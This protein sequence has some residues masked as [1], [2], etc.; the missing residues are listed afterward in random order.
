M[1]S[2]DLN[3]LEKLDETLTRLSEQMP[4]HRRELHQ[5]LAD[6]AQE[7]VRQALSEKAKD[8]TGALSDWQ[9]Q[10]V[11]DYGGYAKIQ[12]AKERFERGYAVGYIT[13]SA[14]SGHLIRKPSGRW[15]HYRARITRRY[16]PGLGF[17]ELSR[18]RAQKIAV[19]AAEELLGS[20]ARELQT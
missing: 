10:R 12:P 11:G 6:R 20:I 16:V 2:L 9:E 4:R 17:Y 3:Q 5:L 13:N 18:S 14:E 1:R 19:D 7:A 8:K 15:K